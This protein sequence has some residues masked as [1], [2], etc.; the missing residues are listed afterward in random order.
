MAPSRKGK[1]GGPR[2]RAPDIAQRDSAPL[3]RSLKSPVYQFSRNWDYGAIAKA[4]ADQGA[5]Q[6]FQLSDLPNYTEFTTLFDSYRIQSVEVIFDLAVPFSV[7][8]TQI[9]PTIIVWPDYDDATAP[10]TQAIADQ[11]MVAERLQFSN[12]TTQ[13]RRRVVPKL[14]VSVQSAGP[15]T[16]NAVNMPA[17]WIDCG[18]PSVNHFGM[19]WWVKNY[20]TGV[21]AAINV[22]YRYHFMMREPR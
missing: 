4:A 10:A 19:K 18:Y 11:V 5:A 12:A 22:S 15:T 6:S 16:V 13:F 8:T 21:S 20:N 3:I 7:A 1:K 2:R 17:S 14:A 9:W